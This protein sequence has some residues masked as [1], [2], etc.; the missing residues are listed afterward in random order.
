MYQQSIHGKG[1]RQS[2]PPEQPLYTV[3]LHNHA[4]ASNQ[5][6]QPQHRKDQNWEEEQFRVMQERKGVVS[7]ECDIGIVGEGR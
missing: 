7:Q 4:P 5:T 6:D 2:N 3:A 1:K